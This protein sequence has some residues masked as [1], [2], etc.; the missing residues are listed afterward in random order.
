[1]LWRTLRDSELYRLVLARKM[2]MLAV[3]TKGQILFCLL[4]V[5]NVSHGCWTPIQ[6]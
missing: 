1:M 2:C 4:V 6:C 5:K 3:Y